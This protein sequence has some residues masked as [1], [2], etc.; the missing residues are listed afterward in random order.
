MRLGL[1]RGLLAAHRVLGKVAHT[2][3]TRLP[4]SPR[5]L[6]PGQG[7]QGSSVKLGTPTLD[8]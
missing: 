4:T 5:G 6:L 3:K 8:S 7:G 2:G 1:H